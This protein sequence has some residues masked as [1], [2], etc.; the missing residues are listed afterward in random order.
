KCIA[1]PFDRRAN[2]GVYT[3]CSVES[4]APK[5]T[6]RLAEQAPLAEGTPSEQVLDLATRFIGS[7]TAAFA[8]LPQELDVVIDVAFEHRG[9][10]HQSTT[11]GF[12]RRVHTGNRPDPREESVQM[13]VFDRLLPGR[14]VQPE[15][16]GGHYDYLLTC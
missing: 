5:G 1:N 6:P 14:H 13:V 16:L 11:V 7:A 8:H 12:H 3:R 9:R 15:Q 10:R 2:E 4:K